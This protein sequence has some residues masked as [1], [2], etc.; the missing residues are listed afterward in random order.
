M[1]VRHMNYII[2]GFILH[3]YSLCKLTEETSSARLGMDDFLADLS[4]NGASLD[5]DIMN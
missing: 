1:Q 3:D 5:D 4:G 2:M